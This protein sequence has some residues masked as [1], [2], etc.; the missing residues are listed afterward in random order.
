MISCDSKSGF[1]RL[2]DGAT[3][4]IQ[5]GKGRTQT[6]ARSTLPFLSSLFDAELT[7]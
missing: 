6:A 5:R 7:V 3:H 1:V 2:I 4:V